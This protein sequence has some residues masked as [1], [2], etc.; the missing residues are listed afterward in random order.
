MAE[1][2]GGSESVTS[3]RTPSSAEDT[4]D[5]G[6]GSQGE[7]LPIES[8]RGE[9]GAPGFTFSTFYD[10]LDVDP[11]SDG[12][13]IKRKYRS[14][15][16]DHH[17]DLSSDEDAEIKFKQLT[18]AK[19]VLTNAVSRQQYNQIG[20]EEYVRENYDNP[21][22]T[23]SAT[24][25]SAVA[26]PPEDTG[27]AAKRQHTDDGRQKRRKVDPDAF[28]SIRDD[29]S[30]DATARAGPASG[31]SAGEAASQR[32]A[33][34]GDTSPKSRVQSLS[35]SDADTLS[36]GWRRVWQVRLALTVTVAGLS[37][38]VVLGSAITGIGGLTT[39]DL[40]TEGS[41]LILSAVSLG[42]IGSVVL[43]ALSAQW[44][45]TPGQFSGPSLAHSKWPGTRM[46]ETG[47][48]KYLR[49][50]F[51]LLSIHSLFYIGT[52]ASGG[53][54]PWHILRE[55]Q[56]SST[57]NYW[58]GLGFDGTTSFAAVL[59]YATIFLFTA[60]FGI[61][62]IILGT[63]IS[64]WW[65]S[66]AYGADTHPVSWELP[67]TIAFVGILAALLG[68][69][70]LPPGGVKLPLEHGFVNDLLALTG[71]GTITFATLGVVGVILGL[72]TASAYSVASR[73]LFT[74]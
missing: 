59:V 47:A 70:Q 44:S 12:E 61:L 72:V 16:K 67:P 2:S 21:S 33:P 66:Y 5:E 73:L 53:P 29:N 43:S 15:I 56:Q 42:F 24:S 10:L 58:F 39:T 57:P 28:K 55:I 9:P 6:V 14:L 32:V 19:E 30:H 17:P 22:R 38:L 50:G 51:L 48:G 52:I 18:E 60:L 7:V 54:Q 23:G 65:N 63:S 68:G 13:T 69:L 37:L 25:D 20:H 41:R 4:E 74:Y 3:G 36:A 27:R 45:L 46:A 40:D 64:V 31:S 49:R 11:G 1:D 8:L 26:A 62:Y 34:G 71:D 35:V